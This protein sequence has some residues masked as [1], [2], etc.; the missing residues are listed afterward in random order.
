MQKIPSPTL[1]LVSTFVSVAASW[2][3]SSAQVCNDL[4]AIA[5]GYSCEVLVTPDMV[6]E[7][8]GHDTLYA[9]ELYTSEGLPVGP[10]LGAAQLND[11]LQAVVTH[12][13]SGQSCTGRLVAIDALA[14]SIACSPL[15]IPCVLPDYSPPQLAALGLSEAYPSAVENCG[16]FSMTFVDGV[17][18]VD[19]IQG[20]VA[21]IWRTWTAADASGNT[22]SCIQPIDIYTVSP[23][24]IV[25]PTDTVLSCEDAWPTPTQTGIPSVFFQQQ[26]WPLGANT[27][28]CGLTVD[29]QDQVIPMCGGS[30]VLLRTWT[31]YNSCEGPG[32]AFVQQH[33]Q[34]IYVVDTTGP[35]LKCPSDTL[36]S[37]DPFTCACHWQLPEVLLSD[38]CSEIAGVSAQWNVRGVDYS[39][40]GNVVDSAGTS[41]LIGKW[42]EPALLPAGEAIV[43]TYTAT[44]ACG[45]TTSCSFRAVVADDVPPSARCLQ[46]T[47]VALNANGEA[48][49][50]AN[51]LDLGSVD[52]CAPVRFKARRDDSSA[53]LTGDCFYDRVHFCCSDVG[54]IVPIVLRV[55]DV[56]V[57]SGAVGIEHF[58]EN[59]NDCWVQVRVVDKL[60]PVCI[61]VPDVSVSCANFDPSLHQY[62]A[63]SFSD[64]CCLDSV[65]A[66]SVD[67]SAFDS[68]CQRGTIVRVFQAVDCQGLTS[69]CSQYIFIDEAL[70]YAVRFPDDLL[71]NDCD[72][73]GLYPPAPQILGPHCS[74]VGISYQD[75]VHQAGKLACYWIEREWKIVDW[76]RYNP[77]A[78]LVEVPNPMP[79]ENPLDTANLPGPIVAPPGFWP[80][81][82]VQRIRPTDAQPTHFGVFWSPNGYLYRQIILIRD[83]VPPEYR[84]CPEGTVQVCDHTTNAAEFWNAPQW[85]HPLVPNS[86]DLCEAAVD[87]AVTARDLCSKGNLNVRYRLFLDLDGDGAQ[88]T[89]VSSDNPPP[90]GTVRYGNALTPD[91]AG[92]ELRPFDLR[93]VPPEEKYRFTIQLGGSA[94]LSGFLRWN[95]E[96]EPFQYALPQLPHGEHRI[97]WT[98]DDGCGNRSVC[99]YPVLVR[100]CRPPDLV[101]LAGLNVNLPH[102]HPVPLYASDFLLSVEDNCTPLSSVRLGIRRADS[103]VGFPQLPNGAPQDSVLFHCAD[104]GE[105]AVEVW[106][107]DLSG[108]AAQC[109][110][111]VRIQD[112]S[113]ACAPV[114]VSVAGALRTLHGEGLQDAVVSL[115]GNPLP[116]GAVKTVSN[117]AGFFQFAAVPKGGDYVLTPFK[118]DDPLNGVSTYDLF[119]LHQHI[120]GMNPLDHPYKIIAA[121]INRSRS[122]TTLDIL[123]LR[124]LI[125]GIYTA[126]PENTSWRFVDADYAFPA[127]NNPFQEVFPEAR[128]LEHLVS[129]ATNERFA[130]I[131]VGDLNGSALPNDVDAAAQERTLGTATLCVRP[132]SD[133]AKGE[134][135]VLF[136]VDTLLNAFQA[137]IHHP[138]RELLRLEPIAPMLWEHFAVFPEREAFTVA[139]DGQARPAWK[140]YFRAKPTQPS[141]VDDALWLSDAITPPAAFALNCPTP[142][143]V[144]LRVDAGPSSP[145]ESR[146]SLEVYGCAP[147]P[148]RQS[149]QLR[150]FLP[151]PTEVLVEVFDPAGRLLYGHQRSFPCGNQ[152]IALQYTDWPAA[153]GLYF[154]RLTADGQRFY[155]TMWR[156]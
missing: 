86:S 13:G 50:W 93:P 3:L 89:V 120:I 30:E 21:R 116:T 98:A 104:L 107:Q 1:R 110:V 42:A 68:L 34:R 77:N 47:Q 138:G 87:L 114:H 79:S 35:R 146:P 124:K 144:S 7:G 70:S 28:A 49:L 128:Q 141:A 137:T 76:C 143:E 95:T 65:F 39:A 73:T 59:A 18:S 64:N 48:W 46:S 102:G 111:P 12:L 105:Q 152:A 156:Q 24:S 153:P 133:S 36:L 81:S 38:A 11:T 97:E 150:F 8:G 115:E 132:T 6:L 5:L 69:T 154:F 45:N 41:P 118:N 139:W 80:P 20:L 127:P 130:A 126:F 94:N 22:A 53:C 85:N 29:H 147:N 103:G 52:N 101:C 136:Y 108:N 27:S 119:L 100:D 148:W 67:R 140:A 75:R 23:K 40:L 60:R 62:P 31:V 57:D 44:D 33:L 131:K 55:Y 113:M 10:I 121:D 155:G 99:A 82:T 135:A 71:V 72:S 106:A 84:G 19:C 51:T 58:A 16:P 37:T 26:W 91:F 61:P 129:D 54:K 109:I 90:A 142:M 15:S 4:S 74:W 32:T 145:L 117:A 83:T 125:L 149:T 9:V 25:F 2:A 17:Q 112:P 134:E 63:P 88:E 66:V 14:P 122:V 92:G 56:P 78:P 151:R 43:F 96:K 123:E